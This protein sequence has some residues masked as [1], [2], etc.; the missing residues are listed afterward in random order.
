M[1]FERYALFSGS[2]GAFGC[3]YLKEYRFLLLCPLYILQG[4]LKSIHI[5]FI[6]RCS[7]HLSSEQLAAGVIEDVYRDSDPLNDV[8]FL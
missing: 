6:R 4:F 3:T 1:K 2:G 8:H 5:H 7:G